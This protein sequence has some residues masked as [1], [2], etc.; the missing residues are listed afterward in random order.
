MATRKRITKAL[1]LRIGAVGLFLGLGTFAVMHS[2]Q[3]QKEDGDQLAAADTDEAGTPMASDVPV[4][5]PDPENKVETV[6][7]TDEIQRDSTDLPGG[8]SNSG[9]VPGFQPAPQKNKLASDP[10]GK[11]SPFAVPPRGATTGKSSRIPPFSQ[12]ESGQQEA[13]PSPPSSPGSFGSNPGLPP[14]RSTTPPSS[15]PDSSGFRGPPVRP[16]GNTFQRPGDASD[17]TSQKSLLPPFRGSVTPANEPE[18]SR[19]DDSLPDTTAAN[20]LPPLRPVDP[21]SNSALSG[22]SSQP[23]AASPG[24]SFGA[25]GESTP[26][27]SG[28][29]AS[30]FSTSPG[31]PAVQPFPPS[32]SASALGSQ[33]STSNDRGYASDIRESSSQPP[34][35][36]GSSGPVS[37]FNPPTQVTASPTRVV[38][39][40]SGIPARNISTPTSP[41]SQTPSTLANPQGIAGQASRI[42]SP[43]PGQRHLEG[44]QIPALAVQKIAP[45]EIQ[46]NREAVFELVVKNTGKATADNVQV[47]DHVPEGTRLVETVPAAD[48]HPNGQITWSLGSLAPGQQTSIKMKLIPERAGNIG[49]VAHVTFGALASA[50][51]VC[52]QPKLAIRH[53]A[54]STVLLGQNL[55]MNIFVENN[56]NGAAEDVVL[57]EDVPEGLVFASG[58]KELQYK[59]GTLMPGQTRRVQL[60]LRAA[61]VGQAKNVL[62]AH[63]AGQLRAT[64]TVDVRVVA[65][66]LDLQTEGPNRKFLNRQA[67]HSFRL[68]NQGSAAATNVQLVARLPRGLQFA[69]ANNQGQY[70][71][72]N[73]A[74]VWRLARLEPQQSGSVQM[75]TLPVA[76]GQLDI[77]VTAVADL[78]QRQQQIQSLAVQQLSEL[79]FDSADTADAIEVGTSTNFRVRVAN[80]GSI[81]ASNVQVSVEFPA[82]LQ[83]LSVQ[84]GLG[85]EIRNQTVVLQNIPSLQ[86]RQEVSFMVT[87]KAVAAG[88]HR[89]VLSVR[90]D[91]REI[92]VS[93]EESTHIYSDR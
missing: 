21:S 68:T 61:Q 19:Q 24:G 39:S 80:Q 72:T 4:V 58:Q 7:G 45:R 71:R 8:S 9:L 16:G 93:K 28:R 53:E 32:Q 74:V 79:F 5:D 92:A 87:A 42:S 36:P 49:S 86:P 12:P 66:Q 56:G 91:D 84:G 85:H 44:V 26:A 63:G 29:Q 43:T 35:R 14:I 48:A 64:D 3:K 65:P 34:L 40:G 59:I 60:P 82:G 76:T 62:V 89:T 54:P 52:T 6:S 25:A 83:P 10:P 37:G 22:S 70:D 20:P 17:S 46:V 15:S 31:P 69:S 30:G 38:P 13:T 11:S 33:E 23:P 51:T 18:T 73:H 50:Q 41:A 75:T 90:T 2:I 47:H 1:L 27:A 81:P 67:T 88:D 57:Q 77:E 55:V 78:N